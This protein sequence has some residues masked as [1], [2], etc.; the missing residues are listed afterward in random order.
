MKYFFKGI[1]LLFISIS[2]NAD[3]IS[4]L[5]NSIGWTIIDSKIIDG[6]IKEN[7]KKE[8][9]FEG[10][11][12]NRVIYFRDGTTVT[13]NSYGYQYAYAPTAIILGKSILYKGK[14]ITLFKMIVEDE[15]Y[16]IQ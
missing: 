14:K 4:A 11:N 1:L 13:C 5:E 3:C 16:N 9:S 7:G 12:Y 8:D 10:C 2:T 15:E 6:Y